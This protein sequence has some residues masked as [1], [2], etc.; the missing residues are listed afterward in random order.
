MAFIRFVGCSVGKKIC[1]ACDTD[2][3]RILPWRGGGEYDV[4]ELLEWAHPY[5]HIC[6]T[7]GEPLDHDLEP[8]I[9]QG[10]AH[11]IFHVE[12]SGT[13]ALPWSRALSLADASVWITVSPK[14]GWLEEVVEAAHEVKV[15]VPGLGSGAGWPTLEDALRWAKT[16]RVFLQPRNTKFD[17]DRMNLTYILD[18]L[19]E[20]PQLHLSVQLHKVL[21]VQ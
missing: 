20:Y 10:A 13:R 1:H 11:H 4:D 8:L 5:Q 9:V 12:T 14:P 15:I 21:R 16:K 7:G 17:V 2:F 6:L 18:L 3:E 19:R